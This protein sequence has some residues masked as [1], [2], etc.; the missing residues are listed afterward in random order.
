ME[1]LLKVGAKMRFLFEIM[2]LTL[3]KLLKNLN[4]DRICI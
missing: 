3:D 4:N 2:K 1:L